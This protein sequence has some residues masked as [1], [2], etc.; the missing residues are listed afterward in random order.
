[1]DQQATVEFPGR[2]GDA[3]EALRSF[4]VFVLP[5]HEE[6]MS[7]ALLEAMAL[8]LP[9]VA[10]SIPGNLR[11]VSDGEHGLLAPPGDPSSLADAILAQWAEFDRA[12]EMGRLARG[13]VK[14]EFS[15]T[16]VARRHLRWFEELLRR[17][18]L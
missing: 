10:T 14:R 12:C 8:G 16:A 13:R 18:R 5:S 9:V 1:M 7:I 17:R 2:V 6:G 11:V 15:I 3:T 4:D